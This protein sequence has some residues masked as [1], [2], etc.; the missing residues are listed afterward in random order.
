MKSQR[1]SIFSTVIIFAIL[2]VNISHS[3]GSVDYTNPS[4]WGGNCQTGL[5]QSPID[6]N[7]KNLTFCPQIN[8]DFKYLCVADSF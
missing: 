8:N 5:S 1:N 4:S 3:S 6:I 7:T 2:F